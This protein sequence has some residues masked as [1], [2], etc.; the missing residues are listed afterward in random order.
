MPLDKNTVHFYGFGHYRT[1]IGSFVVEVEPTV[2][3]DVGPPEVA[4]TSTIR[5]PVPP[6]KHSPGGFSIDMPRRIANGGSGIAYRFVA[7]YLALTRHGKRQS[8][9]AKTELN[10]QN[11]DSLMDKIM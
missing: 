5:S 11:F 8:S 3:V 1:L 9:S 4:E 7:R 2:S 10:L 6:Q